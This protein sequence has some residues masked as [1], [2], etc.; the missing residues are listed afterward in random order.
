MTGHDSVAIGLFRAAFCGDA[1]AARQLLDA[2]AAVDSMDAFENTPLLIA[3]YGGHVAIAKDL[4]DHGAAIDHRNSTADTALLLAAADPIRLAEPYGRPAARH[5]GHDET[6][7]ELLARGAATR[8]L[9]TRLVD[10]LNV[11]EGALVQ[12]KD[13]LEYVR[14]LR[15]QQ[16][17]AS[18]RDY[19]ITSAG[20]AA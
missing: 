5:K 20:C 7:R 15:F 6:V 11:P 1:P 2:R 8:F 4:L 19:G 10:F 14:K 16:N 18:L 13:P 17:V 12:P 9:L 3:A